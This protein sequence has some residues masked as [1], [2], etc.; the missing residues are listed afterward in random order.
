MVRD[1][2]DFLESILDTPSPSGFEQPLQ[3]V[4]KK[5]MSKIADEVTHDLHGNL[6]CAFNPQGK[7]RVMLAGHCDQIG[8]MVTHVD[9][10]GYIWFGAIGGIDALVCPGSV[11][12]ILAESGPIS[13]VIGSRA[14]HL[15]PAG[16][17]GKPLELSK[18]WI[19]IGCKTGADVKKLVRPGDP[20]VYKLG[21]TKLADGRISSPALDDKVGV[22]VVMEAMKLVAKEVGRAK[23]SFPVA[24]Y[25]VSTVQEELGLRGAKTAAY[26]INPIVGIAVDLTHASDNPTAEAKQI[27][28]IKMGGG[29]VVFKGANIN[30]VVEELLTS[31]AKKKKIPYQP[32][33]AP[34]ATGTDANAM[35]VSRA[36]VAA[37]LVSIPNRYMHTQVEMCDLEDIENAAKLLAESILAIRPNADFIPK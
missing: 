22:F 32:S 10:Q 24:L 34:G 11:V 1:S 15:T 35:Q 30:P 20:V 6:I 17:R 13:G 3:R 26:G 14:I 12:T 25:S 33:G 5:Q 36:G 31:T 23:K 29:P 37:A 9:D 16:D 19:D 8:F 18:L 27:G 21:V 2:Y 28:T 4:V 7:I